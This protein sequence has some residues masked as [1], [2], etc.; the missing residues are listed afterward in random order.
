MGARSFVNRCRRASWSFMGEKEPPAT[1]SFFLSDVFFVFF[2]RR[3]F[4]LRRD[5]LAC[6]GIFIDTTKKLIF[7]FKF[8]E[9]ICGCVVK[10]YIVVIS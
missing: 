10:I 7:F 1:V 3:D 2:F 5:T 9:F 8:I 4:I 6:Y